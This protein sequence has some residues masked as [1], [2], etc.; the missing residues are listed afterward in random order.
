[1][2]IYINMSAEQF[3]PL[4]DH[5]YN[6]YVETEDLKQLIS[7]Y[8][9]FIEKADKIA[10]KY[11]F[12]GYF[13]GTHFYYDFI[14]FDKNEIAI[15]GDDSGCGEVADYTF[16]IAWLFMSD[17]EIDADKERRD[18]IK[19]EELAKWRAEE[20]AKEKAKKEAE[21]RALYEELKKKYG[22]S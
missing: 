21:E 16:P 3:K 19:A 4:V 10:N 15:V 5:L 1:M 17:E 20:E 6:K 12:C 13:T 8:N 18:K 22:E 11:Y 14:H 9:E 2:E 7:K